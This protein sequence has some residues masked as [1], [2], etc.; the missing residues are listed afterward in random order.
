MRLPSERRLVVGSVADPSD[1]GVADRTTPVESCARAGSVA[2]E[3]EFSDDPIL[4]EYCRVRELRGV[5]APADCREL[6]LGV[7]L[8]F[9]DVLGLDGTAPAEGFDWAWVSRRRAAMRSAIDCRPVALRSE[10]LGVGLERKDRADSPAPTDGLAGPELMDGLERLNDW[11][12]WLRFTE[13]LWLGATVLGRSDMR[14]CGL[15][16]G[17]A[18]LGTDWLVDGPRLICGLG[19]GRED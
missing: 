16:L 1:L 7:G 12:G 4:E 19:A 6:S 11:L 2:A 8:T 9:L 3:E 18:D 13:G 15:T 17:A 14:L 5:S 10:T